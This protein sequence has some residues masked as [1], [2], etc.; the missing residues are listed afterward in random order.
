MKPVQKEKR[1]LREKNRS[2]TVGSLGEQNKGT[3]LAL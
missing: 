2:A 3:C 1:T